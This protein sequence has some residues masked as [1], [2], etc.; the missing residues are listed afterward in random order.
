MHAQ[1]NTQPAI[2][3]K[4][5]V[6]PTDLPFIFRTMHGGFD[7]ASMAPAASPVRFSPALPIGYAS[8]Q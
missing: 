3:D 8:K 5:R 7:P 6:I 2:P 4:T 1:T